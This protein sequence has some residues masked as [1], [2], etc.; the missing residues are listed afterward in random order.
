MP[1]KWISLI[2]GY[3]VVSTISISIYS[4]VLYVIIASKSKA[5]RSAFFYIFIV[6]GVFDIM[7]V[8][9]NEWVRNDVNICFGPS[10]EMISRLAAAMTGTN[11]LTHLFGS[12]L[13]TLNRFT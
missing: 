4:Y 5:V 6:T 11:S 2:D 7:G 10:F 3:F 12:F 9:A 1:I 13:M 8:I